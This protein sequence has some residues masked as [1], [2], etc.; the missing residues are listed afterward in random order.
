MR[1]ITKICRSKD[2]SINQLKL[3][4]KFYE[5]KLIRAYSG[6]LGLEDDEGR[7]YLRKATGSWI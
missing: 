1:T 6:C 4:P 2:L 3:K 7:D 5:V